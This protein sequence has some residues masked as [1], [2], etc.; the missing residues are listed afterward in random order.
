MA[1]RGNFPSTDREL[2]ADWE[3][4]LP[5]QP[6]IGLC[7]YVLNDLING[8]KERPLVVVTM[9]CSFS[10]YPL[11]QLPIAFTF[12]TGVSKHHQKIVDATAWRCRRLTMRGGKTRELRWNTRL[13]QEDFPCL[14][15]LM[16]RA[17]QLMGVNDLPDIVDCRT[18]ADRRIINRAREIVDLK[19][20]KELVGHVMDQ[21]EVGYQPRRGV[22]QPQECFGFLW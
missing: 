1:A 9:S 15:V 4:G 16:A 13:K 17:V 18:K 5:Q 8:N 21:D 2:R 11:F 3:Q 14:F 19:G 10:R 20:I 7:C 12:P 22:M 6:L